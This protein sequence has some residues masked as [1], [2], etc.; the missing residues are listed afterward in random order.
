MHQ[1]KVDLNPRCPSSWVVS[2]RSVHE[3]ALR[4]FAAHLVERVRDDAADAIEIGTLDRERRRE[5]DHRVEPVVRA[6]DQPLGFH[7]V[8]EPAQERFVVERGAA[9]AVADEFD[10]DE[11]FGAAAHCKYGLRSRSVPIVVIGP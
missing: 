6:A 5:L 4:E 2:P 1:A 9:L 11:E 3:S 7:G 10:A 8:R